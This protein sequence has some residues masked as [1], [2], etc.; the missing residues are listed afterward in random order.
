MDVAVET[1]VVPPINAVSWWD[2][3][4]GVALDSLPWELHHLYSMN[5]HITL[6]HV[7]E[8]KKVGGG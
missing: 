3:P 4:V 1:S 7:L 5:I 6:D 8:R 2:T